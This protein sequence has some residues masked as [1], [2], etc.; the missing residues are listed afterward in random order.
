MADKLAHDEMKKEN[1]A[2][3]SLAIVVDKKLVVSRACDLADVENPAPASTATLFRTGS[4]AKPI[5]AAAAMERCQQGMLDLNAPMQK[6]CPEFPKKQ[7]AITT[8]ELLGHLSGIR[9][10]QNDNSDFFS[11]KHYAHASDS[12]EIFANGSLLFKPRTRIQYSTYGHS[13]V[14]CV[15]E[16]A[17]REEFMKALSELVI[18][19]ANMQ[20]TGV[21]DVF[22]I[23]DG[24]C[25]P[26]TVN[27][28]HS[29]RNATFVGT[30]NKIPGGGLISTAED[31]AVFLSFSNPTRSSMP[32]SPS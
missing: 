7:E 5:T 1:I 16:G 18:A 25:R 11:T 29:L 15:I 4:I 8:R 20:S 3:L 2:G 27:K 30:S 14:G 32:K 17:S 31:L 6:S 22:E 12:F 9:H 26:Y 24:R 10:C 28:D 13:V 19:P 23:I 21:D